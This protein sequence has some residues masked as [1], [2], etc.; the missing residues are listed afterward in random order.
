MKNGIA[1]PSASP[2]V[3]NVILVKKRDGSMRFAIDYRKLNVTVKDSYPMPNVG[4]IVD[5]MKGSQFFII[6][7]IKLYTH[8]KPRYNK[9]YKK[10]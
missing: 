5:E 8:L 7:I 3:S 9:T 6:I 10:T 1:S 2:W 4:V